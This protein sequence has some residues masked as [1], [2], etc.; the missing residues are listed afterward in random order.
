MKLY[1]LV[2]N[3][4]TLQGVDCISVVG[5]P[6]MESTFVAL[7]D[8]KKITFAKVDNE[9]Q[10]LMGVAMIPD[11]KIYRFD[12]QT[13]EEYYVYFSKDTVRKVSELYLKKANQFNANLEHDPD[14]K[15]NATV[16]E[17]WIVE[18]SEKDK[19]ALF[20]LDA[21]VG[22][23]VVSMKIDDKAQWETAKETGTGF[24]I[25]GV[26]SE[27][28]N[29]K[30]QIEMSKNT[31]IDNL[32]VAL[33][34][35]FSSEEA[36]VVETPQEE[37]QL[38]EVQLSEMALK[39][40]NKIAFEGDALTVGGAVQLVT[41]NGNV[42]LPV[43][44]Y[45]LEDGTMLEITEEGIVGELKAPEQAP[46]AEQQPSQMETELSE[47]KN[48]LTELK[49]ENESLKAELKTVNEKFAEV[50][51]APAVERIVTAPVNMEAQTATTKRGRLT[52]ALQNLTK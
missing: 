4:E 44:E 36:P 25:E 30:S 14:Q 39:D 15:I 12:E 21:P 24:S 43:G 9:K 1:E 42:P 23:W 50:S 45:E 31:K 29:L 48:L 52:L 13:Q 40:G 47:V 2:L 11:K 18:D 27:V 37:V 51:K 32:V 46:P 17:S 20:G 8:E 6:A 49:K 33:K 28:V 7:S 3:D 22:S 10:I 26:F 41:E 19:S 35:L 38:E 16:V 5:S 34:A